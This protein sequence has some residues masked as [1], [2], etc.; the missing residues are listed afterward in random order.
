MSHLETASHLEV[1]CLKRPFSSFDFVEQRFLG[2]DPI[3]KLFSISRCRDG[4]SLLLESVAPTGAIAE[5]NEDLSIL[6]PNFQPL[7]LVRI[8]FW[9]VEIEVDNLANLE[10]CNCLG[11]AILKKDWLTL[12][13]GEHWHVYEAVIRP[14]PHPHNY[15]NACSAF[16][17]KAADTRIEVIGC[18]Y[19]QQNGVSKTC[20]QVAIRSAVSTYF[21]RNDLSYRIINNLAASRQPGY[22][23][24]NGLT[25]QQIAEVLTD[26]GVNHLT[27]DYDEVETDPDPNLRVP[28]IRED[29]PYQKL[30]Y[31]GIE[32]SSGALMAIRM[33][34][35]GAPPVGHV[36]PL[37][38]HTFNEDSWV[39]NAE[40]SYFRIGE[41]ISYIPSRSWLS[42]FIAHDDNFGANLCIPHGFIEKK[43]VSCVY[44][45]LPLGWCYSGVDAEIAA[46]DYFYSILPSTPNSSDLPWLVRL[47]SYVQ[48]AHRQRLI[49]RHIPISKDGY[50]EEL[51]TQSDWEGNSVAEATIEELERRIAPDKFWMVE[52]S[53]PEV[54]PTNKRKLGE[55]LLDATRDLSDATD[56]SSFVLARLPGN[57]VFFDSLDGFGVPSFTFTPSSIRSHT[58]LYRPTARI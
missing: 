33:A 20:A 35:P 7:D 39:P 21:Q 19:A 29:L 13:G 37:F 18:L 47:R 2:S 8:S 1:V 52:V 57:F 15:A 36:I 25:N 24:A 56:G 43:L 40:P 58:A 28:T 3:R 31:S 49:L 5:E 44:E 6:D 54:F 42:S 48:N 10:S 27:I 41:H 51:R 12:Y 14:Y 11:Y 32:S 26:L 17:F 16:E 34:G 50:L 4:R 46:S 9:S 45:L 38:G 55:I 23:P 30:I 53:V 22:D